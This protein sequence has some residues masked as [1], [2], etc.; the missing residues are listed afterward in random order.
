MATTA[1]GDLIKSVTLPQAVALYAGAVVGAGVLILPGVAASE[2]GPASLVAWAFDGLLGVPIALTFAALAA[3]F[4]DAG[5]VSIYASRAFGGAVGATV[6]WFYFF[7]AAIAQALVVLAGAHYAG[8]AL[9][10]GSDAT[11]I[12]AATILA[13][14]V[15]ANLRGLRTSA[16]LQLVLSGAVALVLV[17]ATISAL[18]NLELD[19]MSPFLPHGWPSVGDAAVVLFFAFFGWEAITHLSSEFRNPERDVPLATVLSVVLVT[20][21]YLGVAF[22][23]V[24]TGTYG[25]AELDRVAVARVLGDSFGVSA[26]AVAAIAAV[27]I[28]LGTANAFVAATSRLGYALGRDDAFPRAM[29]RVNER[30]V[31][32]VAVVVVGALAAGGL[33]LAYLRSWGAEAFLVVPNSLV[34][35]VYLIGMAAGIRLLGGRRRL[36]AVLAF[37]LCLV[38]LPFAGVALLLPLSVAVAALGYR[39]LRRAR[40]AADDQ[41][42]AM[43]AFE[44]DHLTAVHRDSGRLY[45]EFLRSPSLSAGLYRLAP[46]EDDPQLPHKEDEVYYVAHGHARVRVGTAERAVRPGSLV[47][48]PANVP[49]RFHD[50]REELILLVFFAPAETLPREVRAPLAR[51]YRERARSASSA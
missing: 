6:G 45:Y 17:A 25:N 42:D 36:L 12:A 20:V 24:T 26:Q 35:V 14:A 34:I 49:H 11:F 40:V 8:D 28:T 41:V 33:L 30:G 43:D 22:A 51:H 9:A 47:F 15:A 38:I 19:A 50:V 48:V 5:G 23:V 37:T 3:R 7:A 16:R 13:I 32:A 46:G 1:G 21:L 29:A 4:P 18:P 44:L 10:L 27:V 2:A 39:R 31:P